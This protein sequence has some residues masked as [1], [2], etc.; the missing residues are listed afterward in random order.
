ML[1]RTA[2]NRCL[3]TAYS[4]TLVKLFESWFTALQLS[5]AWLMD[6]SSPRGPD[7]PRAGDLRACTYCRKIALSYAHSADSACIG[8]DLT[9]L[10]DSPCSVCVLEPTEPRTPVGGRKASRNIFLEEDLAWQRWKYKAVNERKMRYSQS[11]MPLF[12]VCCMFSDVVCHPPWISSL[13]LFF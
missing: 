1:F 11:F 2:I 7:P 6:I 5:A 8:E 10:S 4:Q 12:H 3:E 13:L 9:A